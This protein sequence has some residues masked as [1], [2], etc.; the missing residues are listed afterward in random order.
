LDALFEDLVAFS[1]ILEGVIVRNGPGVLNTED[2]IEIEA[3]AGAMGIGPGGRLDGKAL[4]PVRG[5]LLLHVLIGLLNGA[6][7]FAP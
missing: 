1:F 6:N 5:E 4:A 7:V 2:G 3:F